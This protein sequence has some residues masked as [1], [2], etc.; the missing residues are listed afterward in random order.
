MTERDWLIVGQLRKPH[1]VHGDLLAEI[2]TDFPERLHDGARVGI[3]GDSGV[4]R[5][6][7]A[8]SV[9]Y[10]K[11]AWL[12][13]LDIADDR[14]AAEALRGH[15]LYLPEQALDELPEGYY[16]E[17]H[18]VGLECRGTDATVYGT[19]T[20]LDPGPGQTRLIVRKGHREHLVP[21]VDA[22]VVEVDLE[23]GRILLDP[24]DGLFE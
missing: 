19:V 11:G 3:G 17:H 14:D 21:Y 15:Y 23:A 18:L 12:L 5:F 13:T 4:D 24:P 7:T 16:Y 6:A 1:G 2:I 20:G 10:H 22:I 8:S 9:R